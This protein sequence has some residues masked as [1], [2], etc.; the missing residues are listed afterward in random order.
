M[1]HDPACTSL[2]SDNPADCLCPNPQELKLSGIAFV[3]CVLAG[4]IELYAVYIAGSVALFSDVIHIGSDALTYL[5]TFCLIGLAYIF[6]SAQKMATIVLVWMS[7]LLLLVGDWFVLE[8]AVDRM[9]VPHEVL[10]LP[11]LLAAVAGLV[12]N[13][14]VLFLSR[15]TPRHE[16]NV[17]HA[18]IDA[19]ALSD[20]AVSVAVIVAAGIIWLTDWHAA[21]WMVALGVAFYLFLGPIFD[22][23]WRIVHGNTRAHGHNHGRGQQPERAEHVPSNAL[24]NYAREY[25][26]FIPE[27]KRKRNE[28]AASAVEEQARRKRLK[29][30]RKRQKRKRKR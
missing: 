1:K 8:T 24:D 9:F 4:A 28:D 23:V 20:L 18:S 26:Y 30:K 25:G 22:L 19:H 29:E 15:E 14:I 16:Q 11:T 6:R 5:A 10:G 21:D 13:A 17:R 12:L 7:L 3:L 27:R 2:A